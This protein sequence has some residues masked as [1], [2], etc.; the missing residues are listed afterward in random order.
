M[1]L[2]RVGKV[3]AERPALLD[4]Y[5][6]LRDLSRVVADI[7][8]AALLPDSLLRLAQLDTAALPAIPGAPRI[9]PCVANIGKI[10]CVGLNYRDHAAEANM[11]LPDEP[12]LFL[13]A[14]SAIVGPD[15]DVEI[16]RGSEKT[17]WEVELG[18]VIGKRGKYITRE[19]ALE[20][21][22]GYCVVNDVSERSY[23]LE[24]GGQ[25]DKGKG[26][27]TFAPIGPWL[28]TAEE[29]GD[30]QNLDLWLEVDNQR[31]QNG[32]TRDMVFGVTHLIAYISQFMSLRSGDVIAT[33]TPAGVGMGL[34][35][36]QFL[37]A[38]QCVRV[39]IEGLGV[40]TQRTVA[41]G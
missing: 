29:I 6:Q 21:V 26:C 37:R 16:P 12:I 35:P 10:I 15:D 31:V 30:P 14:T 7:D 38:G 11:K 33:G 3:G 19:R 28:V 9:G 17:D 22:A 25:W 2:L 4:P 27:D 18:I 39:G 34:K 20:H 36:P 8:G 40:Q 1:K 24:R 5:G 23:Q 32:N 41:A 13:K